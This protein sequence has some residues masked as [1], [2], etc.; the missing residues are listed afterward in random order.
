MDSVLIIKIFQRVQVP[1]C[2][3]RDL[4]QLPR[5]HTLFRRS[6]L[7]D[8]QVR[9]CRSVMGFRGCLETQHIQ[10]HFTQRKVQSISMNTWDSDHA[11]TQRYVLMPANTTHVI[12]FGTM[13]KDDF[14]Y[15]LCSSLFF[16]FNPNPAW[17]NDLLHRPLPGFAVTV[18]G[19]W[20]ATSSLK[21]GTHGP[22]LQCLHDVLQILWP[23]VNI[24]VERQVVAAWDL[25]HAVSLSNEIAVLRM[26]CLEGEDTFNKH[27]RVDC[28]NQDQF[29]S[30]QF[31]IMPHVFICIYIYILHMMKEMR[32]S[33]LRVSGSWWRKFSPRS[34]RHFQDPC[35]LA[36]WRRQSCSPYLYSAFHRPF[37]HPRILQGS[38]G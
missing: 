17:I 32:R 28:P 21:H 38:E 27:L 30:R 15:I 20:Q 9:R 22:S 37:H 18:A 29:I 25:T 34:K 11:F 1:P 31:M 14:V 8:I 4:K 7:F 10:I 19:S 12:F 6:T 33:I 23:K 3:D 2:C 5:S 36:G 16:A 26:E 35:C 24:A 13:N